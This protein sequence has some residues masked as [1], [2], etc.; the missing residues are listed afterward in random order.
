MLKVVPISHMDWTHISLYLYISD[1]SLSKDSKKYNTL[2]VSNGGL[3]KGIPVMNERV[4]VNITC[5]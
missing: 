5:G 2:L 1:E 3:G 4:K